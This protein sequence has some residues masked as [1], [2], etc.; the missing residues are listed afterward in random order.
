MVPKAGDLFRLLPSDAAGV[1]LPLSV[2]LAQTLVEKCL[3]AD[4][5]EGLATVRS[6][7]IAVKVARRLKW[8]HQILDLVHLACL[9][10]QDREENRDAWSISAN[11]VL[12]T[13]VRE[14]ES[15][16]EILSLVGT[17]LVAERLVRE[18]GV[19]RGLE[20]LMSWSV[21]P[22]LLDAAWDLRYD[23]QLW[24]RLEDG[25]SYECLLHAGRLGLLPVAEADRAAIP[26]PLFCRA[27]VA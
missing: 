19:Y 27:K 2:G 7:C 21:S 16:R 9:G 25:P 1:D 13:V 4:E 10:R 23:E 15:K 5:E 6:S 22:A 18:F 12:R 26:L 24:K 17:C 14:C 8:P 20:A 3:D 11:P